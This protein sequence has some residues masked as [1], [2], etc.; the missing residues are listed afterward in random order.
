MANGQSPWSA[1]TGRER[2]IFTP[3]DRDFL[4]GEIEEELDDNETRQKRFQIRQRVVN[5]ILDFAYFL[6]LR[7]E[8]VDLITQKVDDDALFHYAVDYMFSYLFQ[9]LGQEEF[10]D[11]VTDVVLDRVFYRI[12]FQEDVF[13]V[14]K[15]DFDV[16]VEQKIPLDEVYQKY[17]EGV[18]LG[19]RELDALVVTDRI[20]E[21]ELSQGVENEAR[22][23]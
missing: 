20:S 10:I 14:V 19:E 16:E 13:P 7:P 3:R 21:E 22:D 4:T 15:V 12:V 9:I 1:D 18:D 6:H 17:K 2:G 11:W 23:R 8:D 5:S